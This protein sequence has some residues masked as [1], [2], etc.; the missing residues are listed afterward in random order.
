MTG[1]F[2]FTPFAGLSPT[3]GAY[4][5]SYSIDAFTEHSTVAVSRTPST[6]V[7]SEDSLPR[8]SD[9]EL[10]RDL[11]SAEN[12]SDGASTSRK[13]ASRPRVRES[14]GGAKTMPAWTTG[15]T[16]A[17]PFPP[18]MPPVMTAPPTALCAPTPPVSQTSHEDHAEEALDLWS[19]GLSRVLEGDEDEGDER[20]ETEEPATKAPRRRAKVVPASPGLSLQKASATALQQETL[21]FLERLDLKS[22][23]S[24]RP[25]DVT[26]F[27]PTAGTESKTLPSVDAR[28]EADPLRCGGESTARLGKASAG[29]SASARLAHVALAYG[30]TAKPKKARQGTFD[31]L[32]NPILGHSSTLQALSPEQRKK[33]EAVLFDLSLTDSQSQNQRHEG[34]VPVKMGPA[35]AAYEAAASS[36]VQHLRKS[37]PVPSP[38]R[39]GQVEPVHAVG[40]QEEDA[41]STPVAPATRSSR[42]SRGGR[43]NRRLEER[44]N[45]LKQRLA[46]REALGNESE[47]SST[48]MAIGATFLTQPEETEAPQQASMQPVACA[49]THPPVVPTRP[50]L[51]PAVRVRARQRTPVPETRPTESRTSR[52]SRSMVTATKP[53]AALTPKKPTAARKSSSTT[54][55]FASSQV[56][57]K[58]QAPAVASRSRQ[59]KTDNVGRPVAQVPA[60]RGRKTTPSTASLM[61]LGTD[62]AATSSAPPPSSRPTKNS[63]GAL[64]PARS[65]SRPRGGSVEQKTTAA[66]KSVAKPSSSGASARRRR[67]RSSAASTTATMSLPPLQQNSVPKG[68]SDRSSARTTGARRARVRGGVP[69]TN[70]AA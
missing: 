10:F 47:G 1:S 28:V 5:P 42:K 49:T 41:K 17:M 55:T 60:Q 25:P 56:A 44:K 16:M 23:L 36:S 7:L 59:S 30:T 18:A 62:A 15:A 46:A 51:P 48:R 65:S 54:D 20:P 24:A 6:T 70:K 4:I 64:A 63:S 8:M 12:D 53:P 26:S 58:P 35:T 50:S 57:P 9:D 37:K 32:S 31:R 22:L 2:A 68:S 19:G 14:K 27:F 3:R 45:E 29:G 61:L 13:T 38:T 67:T 34:G 52:P 66:P 21:T 11:F 43:R 40:N 39:H 69:S 33:R